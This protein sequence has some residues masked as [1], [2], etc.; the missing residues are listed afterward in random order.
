M[1]PDASVSVVYVVARLRLVL[2]VR[3]VVSRLAD[4]LQPTRETARIAGCGRVDGCGDM[5]W[6]RGRLLRR[7]RRTGA[8]CVDEKASKAVTRSCLM[9]ALVPLRRPIIASCDTDSEAVPWRKGL[10]MIPPLGTSD[11]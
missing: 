7:G 3:P 1:L 9:N 5:D 11:E 4:A 6:A 8:V 2:I 10:F